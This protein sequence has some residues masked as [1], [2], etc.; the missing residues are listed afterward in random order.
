MLHQ[1]VHLIV[2]LLDGHSSHI[3]PETI[4]FTAEEGII[5]FTLPPNTTHVTQP[6]D[7]GLFGP[8]KMAW[9][10]GVHTFLTKNPG[11][12]VSKF[13]FSYFSVMP[14]ISP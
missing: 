3:C 9:R 6:L 13:N 12:V 2:L 8:L 4:R 11:S 5:V 14:G 1:Y 10:Q 7:K